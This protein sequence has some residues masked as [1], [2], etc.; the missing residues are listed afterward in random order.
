[1]G[2][3]LTGPV[4]IGGFCVAAP[5]SGAGGIASEEIGPAFLH[6]LMPP[7]WHQ[8]PTKGGPNA[9]QQPGAGRHRSGASRVRSDFRAGLL[10][11]SVEA[12]QMVGLSAHETTLAR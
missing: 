2:E 8:T 7:A 1:L 5:S 10:T 9:L 12:A 4:A 6:G 3:N 11:L